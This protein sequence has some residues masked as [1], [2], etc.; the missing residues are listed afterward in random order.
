MAAALALAISSSWALSKSVRRLG[1]LLE[2]RSDDLDLR[3]SGDLL[4]LL[5]PEDRDRR[6]RIGDLL[7]LRLLPLD[8]DRL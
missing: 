4:Y 6:S 3:R 1:D 5:L 2:N 7:E 8:L